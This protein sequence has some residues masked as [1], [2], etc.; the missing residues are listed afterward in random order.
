MA[1]AE[2]AAAVAVIVVGGHS[3]LAVRNPVGAYPATFG[4]HRSIP[5]ASLMSGKTTLRR[6][7]EAVVRRGEAVVQSRQRPFRPNHHRPAVHAESWPR[8]TSATSGFTSPR[9]SLR[10]WVQIAVE[11]RLVM[12]MRRPGLALGLTN[13][14]H[15]G[16][17][18]LLGLY[19]GEVADR[20]D[21]RGVDPG[22]SRD[23]CRTAP[24]ARPQQRHRFGQVEQR[25]YR[26]SV[27]WGVVDWV[28]D[29]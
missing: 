17:S 11:N 2:R 25:S 14:L 28:S 6:R 3:G 5:A 19:G 9:R 29:P 23:G 15:L 27:P 16:P 20:Y 22:R 26:R 21:A 24:W 10:P 4:C 8:C 12:D 13:A 1:F 18:L 7:G